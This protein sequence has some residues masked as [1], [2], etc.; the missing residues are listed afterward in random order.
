VVLQTGEQLHPD[1]P[2]ALNV[3]PA[4]VLGVGQDPSLLLVNS[5]AARGADVARDM[6]VEPRLERP[7]RGCMPA[8]DVLRLVRVRGEPSRS[9]YERGAPEA[10]TP[11]ELIVQHGEVNDQ[12]QVVEIGSQVIHND[13]AILPAPASV[14][15]AD[16]VRRLPLRGMKLRPEG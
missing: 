15:C 1:E 12:V 5:I 10:R 9:A 6:P 14:V 7:C 13:T 16:V 2:P 3:V 4:V 11:S 8:P